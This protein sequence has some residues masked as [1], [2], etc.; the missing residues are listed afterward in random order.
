[1]RCGHAADASLAPTNPDI[2]LL[3]T[4]PSVG[5]TRRLT[6]LDYAKLRPQGKV[7]PDGPVFEAQTLHAGSLHGKRVDRRR[8][9]G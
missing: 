8:W 1:M 2:V 7:I 4:R 9:V 3:A 6:R 5:R